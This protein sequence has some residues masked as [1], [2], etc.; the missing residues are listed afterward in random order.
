MTFGKS[1][2]YLGVT[3]MFFRFGAAAVLEELSE[4]DPEAMKPILLAKLAIFDVQHLG[5]WPML[6]AADRP[7]RHSCRLAASVGG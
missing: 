7:A 4:A 2:Y 5:E 3:H 6:L 1:E